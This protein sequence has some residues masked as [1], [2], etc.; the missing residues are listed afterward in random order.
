MDERGNGKSEFRPSVFTI[1]W[2]FWIVF[3]LVVEF[4]ALRR[5]EKQDTFSEHWWALFRV[6]EK[7]PAPV[8]A[9][10]LAVQLTFGVWL[11]GHLAF[12]IWSF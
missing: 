2:V 9:G 4:L 8:R 6:R 10:L 1:A 3:F 12:G 5:K 11:V 7:V